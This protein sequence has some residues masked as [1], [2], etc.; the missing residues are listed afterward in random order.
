MLYLPRLLCFIH[1]WHKWRALGS[2]CGYPKNKKQQLILSWW[3]S[4]QPLVG[5]KQRLFLLSYHNIIVQRP[6]TST[7]LHIRLKKEVIKHKCWRSKKKKPT[8][9]LAASGSDHHH[10]L[11]YTY[12]LPFSSLV[13]IVSCSWLASD[14]GWVNSCLGYFIATT[15]VCC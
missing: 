8:W 1:I 11:A 7:L 14:G 3:S 4:N 2:G 6:Q 13:S 15:F 12:L 9:R 10:T 5:F